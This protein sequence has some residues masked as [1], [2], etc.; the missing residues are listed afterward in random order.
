MKFEP[1]KKSNRVYKG[2]YNWLTQLRAQA[3]ILTL[4]LLLLMIALTLGA[5]FLAYR[6][7]SQTLAESRDQELVIVGAERLSQRMEKFYAKFDHAGR[8]AGDAAWFT[9]HSAGRFGASPRP[10][11]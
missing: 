6:Q 8:P 11:C 9:K 10:D 3:I 7:V 5:T 4:V 2:I 1:G